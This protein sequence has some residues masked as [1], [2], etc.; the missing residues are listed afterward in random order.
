MREPLHQPGRLM[1]PSSRVALANQIRTN[2][3]NVLNS[4][5]IHPSTLTT[6][7]ASLQSGTTYSIDF[8]LLD[9]AYRHI[10]KA[11]DIY[12]INWLAGFRYG[13]M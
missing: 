4:Q 9:L 12:A 7:A 10:F 13:K 2:G 1:D 5:I 6:G 8:Q 3:D 11:S